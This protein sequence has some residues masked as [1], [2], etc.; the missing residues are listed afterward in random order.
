MSEEWDLRKKIG[1]FLGPAL[2]FITLAT[3]IDMPVSAH[4]CLAGAL[5]IAIWW[6]TEAIPIAATSMLP[7]I[8]IPMLGIGSAATAAA[9][10]ANKNVILF[11]GG[12]MIAEALIKWNL[13]RRLSLMIVNA[14]GVSPKRI[15][16]GFMVAAAV[17][18]MWISNTATT[19]A[20]MPIGLAVTY[21]VIDEI[22]RQH[23][24]IPTSRGKFNFG[25]AM[26]LGIAFGATM[27]G[28]G[29]PI[30][31]PPNIVFIGTLEELHPELSISFARWIMFGLPIVAI[32]IPTGWFILTR[33]FTPRFKKIPGGKELIRS[34]IRKL[35][36]WSK[37]E[38]SAISIFIFTAVMWITRPFVINPYISKLI[39]DSTIA[40][41]GAVLL[42]VV[43]I[44]W[45]KGEFTIDWGWAVKIPWG[46]LLL[47]GGGLSLAKAIDVSGLAV[48]LGERLVVFGTLSPLLIVF[49]IAIFTAFLSE[50]TSNT[51]TTA[52]MMPIMTALAI[53]ISV[54]PI[55]PMLA[56][57]LSASFV[58]LLPVGTP[59]NAVVY[60]SG[61]IRV[62]DMIRGGI[63]IKTL[64]LLI[65]SLL[66][67]YLAIPIL[68]GSI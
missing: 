29:T 56:A 23:L 32:F 26:M 25:I 10:Y 14:I 36:S 52:T 61:Y 24:D 46:I 40:I 1:L 64:H 55:V 16:L 65:G 57:A 37:G 30:G 17:L 41:L 6:I 15:I 19:M 7:L 21:L 18:S 53:A 38:K 5:W 27:G 3:P 63:W 67:Y 47:F 35:G 28:L 60:G 68:M 4:R 42:F 43:P 45:E 62:I 12:F 39:D 34:E 13:H 54:S 11:M 9:P 33:V 50:I 48:W 44:S 58:Y 22:K 31:T 51:A 8:L 66:I 59:P 2:F 20:I 49:I